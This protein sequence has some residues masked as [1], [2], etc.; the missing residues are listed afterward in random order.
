MAPPTFITCSESE[1]IVELKRFLKK[2]GVDKVDKSEVT[3]ENWP[4]VFIKCIPLLRVCWKND[5]VTDT[6]SV[7]LLTTVSSLIIVLPPAHTE[8]AVN[9]LCDLYED[10]SEPKNRKHIAK[11]YS[12]NVLFSGL[13]EEHHARYRIYRALVSCATEL[14]ALS[15]IYTQTEK[16]ASIL[17]VCG[18]SP[19]ECQNLWRQM[20]EVHQASG[21]TK[22]ATQAMINLLSTYSDGGAAGAR[23]DAFKCILAAIQDP[24]F[25][26]HNRLITLKPV[27]YLEG[28]P[29]H[30][31]LEIYVSG[32][33]SDFASFIKKHPKFL[34]EHGL[35]EKACLDKLRT[36]SLME[37]AENVAELDYETV[38]CKIDLPEDQLEAFI[39]EAVRQRVITCKL[40]QIHRR[41]LITGA[42]PRN[43]GRP[44][45]QSLYSTLK[46]WETG[47]RVVQNSLRTMIGTAVQ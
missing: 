5:K 14:G 22:L 33:L 17:K 37:I 6:E 11:L 38:C 20:Y 36:L 4:S 43:F 23:E 27:Q 3:Q 2:A 16:V 41:I 32:G 30:K 40:D 12:L 25:L 42:L 19:A 18:C 28:E 39:I 35:N 46:E 10:F 34:A 24:S 13:P 7:D 26:S 44:Q 8:D 45:W 1:Q 31:L 9:K 47:L 15:Q 21:N 29:V